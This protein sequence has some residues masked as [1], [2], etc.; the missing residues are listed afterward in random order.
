[1]ISMVTFKSDNPKECGIVEVDKDNVLINYYEKVKNPPSNLANAIFA[2]MTLYSI[3][4]ILT[5]RF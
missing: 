3:F 5:K 2:L 1:M 4:L